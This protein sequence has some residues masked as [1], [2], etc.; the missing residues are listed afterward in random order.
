MNDPVYEFSSI[1]RGAVSGGYWYARHNPGFN[2]GEASNI[3]TPGWLRFAKEAA[4]RRASINCPPMVSHFQLLYAL[5]LTFCSRVPMSLSQEPRSSRLKDKKRG[6]GERMVKECFLQSVIQNND[7]LH[8]LSSH[9]FSCVLLPQNTSEVSL[10]SN[11]CI[12][13]QKKI[14]PVISVGVGSNT[15]ASEA[16]TVLFSDETK[17]GT[18]V[19]LRSITGFDSVNETSK[20]VFRGDRV[21]SLPHQCNVDLSTTVIGS[22][23]MEK[24]TNYQG[25]GLLDHGRFPC[26]QCGILSF[27]CVAVIQ[28]REAASQCF[29]SAD[30]SFF[31]DWKVGSGFL[32]DTFSVADE[33][34]TFEPNCSSGAIKKAYQGGLYDVPVQT[35][36]YQ[37]QVSDEMVD[38]VSRTGSQKGISS[39]DLLVSAYG[40]SSESDE[41]L[42]EPDMVVNDDNI[43]EH[44]QFE[45]RKTFL[46]K[47]KV[48]PGDS[49]LRSHGSDHQDGMSEYMSDS[50]SKPGSE[51]E[52][53]V[54][55]SPCTS[56]FVRKR[57]WIGSEVKVESHLTSNSSLK[58]DEETLASRKL[59]R[60]VGSYRDKGVFS[61]RVITGSAKLNET[62]L[63]TNQ[64]DSVPVDTRMPS[65]T[66]CARPKFSL[67]GEKT[68]CSNIDIPI[69]DT[70]TSLM[71]IS[72]E[73]SSRK[74]I[75][76]LEHAVEV[77]KQLRPI[78]GASIL[79]L[80]HP[81]Y[82]KV[83][84]EAKVLA[85]DMGIDYLWK[86]I[87]FR[88][89]TK[90]D[91][92]RISFALDD[93]EVEPSNG[94]W[95]VKLGINLY[96]SVHLSKSPLYT[97]QMPYNSIIYKAFRFSSPT[98]YPME[99]EVSGKVPNKQK[100]TLV[101][102]KWCGKVWMLNQVHPSL[103]QRETQEEEN[104]SS[105]HARAVP[106]LKS[107]SMLGRKAEMSNQLKEPVNCPTRCSPGV[108]TTID[109]KFGQKQKR[110]F[111]EEPTMKRKLP[112][113]GSP[114]QTEDSSQSD[115]SPVS[116]RRCLKKG[117]TKHDRPLLQGSSV[118]NIR[119]FDSNLKVEIDGGPS[120]RLRRRPSKLVEE[121]KVKP[122]IGKQTRTKVKKTPPSSN[123]IEDEEAEYQCDIDGCTMGFTSKQ[124][125]TLHKRNVCSVKGCGKNFFSHKYL[126]QHRRVH[127]DDRPLKCPWKGCKMTFKWAWARTEHIRVHTGARPY[128]CREVG[129]GQT[130]RFV[131]D[132]SR[133]KRKTGHSVKG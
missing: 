48:F 23:D 30:C 77:E 6:E 116:G 74:H 122:V 12:G 91:Q 35:S 126:V 81:E 67:L 129:C 41:E 75:F 131:S 99:V 4:V 14:K 100:K 123:D 64:L 107:C 9:G 119:Q 71:Q 125:L 44:K 133:H 42:V 17:L 72:Q 96:Y 58:I 132:F 15:E 120:T 106:C 8:I 24:D 92:E 56:S 101:A 10:L 50:S 61:G 62:G 13:T 102:G 110:K 93:K 18:N 54:Q 117:H 59:K 66:L 21:G 52:V 111:V 108:T 70:N 51:D 45:D 57:R 118:K 49:R 47:T 95:A 1:I 94:D 87:L 29:M 114:A 27:A 115:S 39:L 124:E 31:N 88:D 109:G 85:E 16:S 38:V 32:K 80:C 22:A 84:A 73:E 63:C 55:I 83:E 40:E 127:L 69:L 43:A 33:N 53:S 11:T 46:W 103:A 121:V 68:K 112:L 130:F 78:G 36:D 113:L 86:D 105:Y 82:P 25:T 26:V 2:C 5:A 128:I 37:V 76:C 60:L 79:L 65:N 97:K 19:R 28:P 7:L 89:A 104:S 98:N 3:A 20:P 90:E 34:E